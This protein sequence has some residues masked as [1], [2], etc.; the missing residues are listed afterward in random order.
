MGKKKYKWFKYEIDKKNPKIAIWTFNR[1][2]SQNTI[3]PYNLLPELREAAWT[4]D[5]T[6][7]VIIKGE[8]RSFGSGYGYEG[9]EEL[10]RAMPE[11]EELP[12]GW[13]ASR[14]TPAMGDP[15]TPFDAHMSDY[16]NTYALNY[17]KTFWEQENKFFIAQV[18][19]FCIAGSLELA[20]HCDVTYAA[21]DAWFGYPVT[22]VMGSLCS[23]LWYYT[24]GPKK[25][26]EVMCT[27]GM[28]SAADAYKWGMVN[29]VYPTQ[30]DLEKG[31]RRL[32]DAVALMSPRAIFNMK[33]QRRVLYMEMGYY[34][35]AH[36]MGLL[37][38]VLHNNT[39]PE[40]REF[41]RLIMEQGPRAAYDYCNAPF[42]EFDKEWRSARAKPIEQKK[43]AKRK[44][45]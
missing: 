39:T 36:I 40:A 2:N 20:L 37:G 29:R 28:I 43:P 9:T 13:G 35:G 16:I 42:A 10:T 22:R 32:A 33:M 38:G 34:A 17:M 14:R 19:G 24:M 4:D 1:P 30:K 21:D 45:K 7:V 6:Q 25:T 8:G 3:P 12:V 15:N 23:P 44:K 18:H 26:I 11:W 41:H 5:G 27:G 31:V